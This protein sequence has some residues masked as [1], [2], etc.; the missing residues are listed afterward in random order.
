M[1]GTN[2]EHSGSCLGL[3]EDRY[4]TEPEAAG[5]DNYVSHSWRTQFNSR[6]SERLEWIG[7]R[8]Q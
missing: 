1:R 3:G 2:P 5:G 8:R 7:A 6:M 4:G